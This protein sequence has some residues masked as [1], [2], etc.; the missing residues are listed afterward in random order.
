M[1]A[2][3]ER[4]DVYFRMNIYLSRGLPLSPRESIDAHALSNANSI[5]AVSLRIFFSRL[6]VV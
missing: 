1:K 6:L 3:L 4:K 5:P 2:F